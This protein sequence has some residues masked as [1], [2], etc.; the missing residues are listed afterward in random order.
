MR[1]VVDQTMTAARSAA[2]LAPSRSLGARDC[3][4]PDTVVL[5]RVREW[6]SLML[7]TT[8]HGGPVMSEGRRITFQQPDPASSFDSACRL[9]S[10]LPQ[11]PSRYPMAFTVTGL[12]GWAI[13]DLRIA[14]YSPR[15]THGRRLPRTRRMAGRRA[16]PSPDRSDAPP[17]LCQDDERYARRTTPSR[18]AAPAPIPAIPTAARPSTRERRSSS[19]CTGADSGG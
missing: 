3:G 8:L 5:S 15:N 11:Q 19:W 18:G 17:G 9:W 14:V 1:S 4:R 2:D 6:S 7:G 12:D 13:P 10:G 16:G